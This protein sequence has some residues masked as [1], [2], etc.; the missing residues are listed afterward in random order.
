M[1]QLE[2]M[3]TP[4]PS[5]PR[6]PHYLFAHRAVPRAFLR[7]PESILPIMASDRGMEFLSGMWDVID[8]EIEPQ[9]RID[10]GALAVQTYELPSDIWVAM[11][12]MPP[13]QR[14]FEAYFVACAARLEGDTFARALT[15][16][17][18]G[19]PTADAET[20]VLEWDVEGKHEF[21]EPGC[22]PRVDAFIDVLERL[23][24]PRDAS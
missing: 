24:V 4:P 2:A 13:P 5:E 10:H 19:P 18:A 9:Q 21:L 22:P 6:V 23:L 3:N 15:L 1:G 7:N 20:G 11:V 12:T 14:V 16:D 17:L 8:R